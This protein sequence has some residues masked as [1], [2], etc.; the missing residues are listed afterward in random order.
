M[1]RIIPL[2][3]FAV[4]LLNGCSS[5]GSEQSS[6]FFA[7]IHEQNIEE[8][9]HI[10]YQESD[11]LFY[12]NYLEPQFMY[13]D[14]CYT[15]EDVIPEGSYDFTSFS[16]ACF[17]VDDASVIYAK[18]IFEKVYPA[19]T[20]K[21][22]TA[23]TAIMYGDENAVIEISEDNC[24]IDIAGAQL[25]GFKKGDR[26]SF[27]D[28][29]KCLLIYS[30]NDAGVALAQSISGTEEEYVKLM[31]ATAAKIGAKDTHFVNSHGLHDPKHYTTAYD[32]YLIFSECLKYSVLKDIF[33]TGLTY[34]T[35]VHADGEEEQLKLEPTNLYYTGKYT[36][37]KG[38]FVYGGKTGVTISA[39]NCLVL[40][41][42]DEDGHGFVTELFKVDDKNKMYREMNEL[43]KLAIH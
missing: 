14:I 21:L 36:A 10:A 2:I 6:S 31:N 42:E 24:G 26:I 5:G 32:I 28:L 33:K 40:Y 20:T 7:E 8:E 43:L 9:P 4:I 12:E 16:A 35:I 29:L 38:I 22:L 30:G 17:D 41:S 18:N 19:S 15:K 27:T 3:L 34:A 37:P 39:G 11:H 1:E 13:E 23:L 25:C